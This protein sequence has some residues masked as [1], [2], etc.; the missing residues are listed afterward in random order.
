MYLA[1]IKRKQSHHLL[2]HTRQIY[3]FTMK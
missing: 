1:N 2:M 3:F